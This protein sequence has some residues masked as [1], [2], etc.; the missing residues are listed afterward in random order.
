MQGVCYFINNIPIFI[1]KR[2][3]YVQNINKIFIELREL[4]KNRGVTAMIE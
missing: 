1:L 2:E 4:F 3:I